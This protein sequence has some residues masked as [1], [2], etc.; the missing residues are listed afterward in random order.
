MLP[1]CGLQPLSVALVSSKRRNL[2]SEAIQLYSPA[3]Q[4]LPCKDFC[5]LSPGIA[6]DLLP[7]AF[8][9]LTPSHQRTK[10]TPYLMTPPMAHTAHD[11]YLATANQCMALVRAN[12]LHPPTDTILSMFPASL[13]CFPD[14]INT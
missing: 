11:S 1:S 5:T 13:T 4:P 9:S 14:L 6:H 3:T 7:A 12:E 8:S 2:R 10:Y